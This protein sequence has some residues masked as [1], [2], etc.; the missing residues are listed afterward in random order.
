MIIS[1]IQSAK[2][3]NSSLY[4]DARRKLQL[5]SGETRKNKYIWIGIFLGGKTS[6]RSL[7]FYIQI[8][9]ESWVSKSGPCSIPLK[10][11]QIKLTLFFKGWVLWKQKPHFLLAIGIIY[12]IYRNVIKNYFCN[13]C[14]SQCSSVF[15][16]D[17]TEQKYSYF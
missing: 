17:I 11:L 12:I 4:K 9:N 8:L 1:V 14:L 13:Y 16:C 3:T 10:K 6:S 7:K 2:Q 15:S 5:M